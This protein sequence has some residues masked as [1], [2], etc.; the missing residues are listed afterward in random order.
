[1]ADL[2]LLKL[3]FLGGL[4]IHL[5]NEPVRLGGSRKAYG[6]LAYLTMAGQ[7]GQQRAAIPRETLATLFWP[8]ND[9][10]RALANL[11][12]QL[13]SLRQHLAP[14]LDIQ[15]HS[16]A[17]VWQPTVE[18]D[19][20]N[21]EKNLK[22]AS[23]GNS[24]TPLTR[25]RAAR[26]SAAVALYAGDFLA[27]FYLRN[28]P[29]FDDWTLFHQERLRLKL[30]DGLL[31]LLAFYEERHQIEAGIEHSLRLLQ[32]DPLNETGHR[33]LMRFQA[34]AGQHDLAL[35][36]FDELVTLLAVE[37]AVPPAAET[38]A[39]YEQI[40]DDPASFTPPIPAG[41]Q[42]LLPIPAPP[43]R[44]VGR[45]DELTQIS[46]ALANPDCRLL[47]ITG[48]GG[49]GKSRLAATVARQQ[50]GQFQHGV[51][52]LPLANLHEETELALSLANSLQIPLEHRATIADQL[53]SWLA[54]RELLLVLDNFE[55]LRS[56][57]NLAL[58]QQCLQTA[59]ELKLLITSR[60]RLN[61]QS[62][63]TLALP[64]LALA[65]ETELSPA[66][67]L[68]LER[69]AQAGVGL[70]QQP[71]AW[72]AVARI[73][74]LAAGQPLA[75][76]LAASWV[77]LLSPTE[78][79]AE[80]EH[81]ISFL[82][83]DAADL[84]L[85]HRSLRAV[86]DSSWLMLPPAEQHLYASLAIFRG[87]FS[88]AAAREITGATLLQL[89]ALVDKSLLGRDET[90]RFGHH[91]MLQE[92]A[93]EQLSRQPELLARCRQN[94]LVYYANWAT[95][96]RPA[97]VG[98]SL[99]ETM[100]Q[101]ARE[102]DN[103]RQAWQIAGQ[104]AQWPAIKQLFS[105]LGNFFKYSSQFYTARQWLQPMRQKLAAAPAGTDQD[106]LLLLTVRAAQFNSYLNDDVAASQ[107]LQDAERLALQSGDQSQ[108]LPIYQLM[109]ILAESQGQYDEAYDAIQKGLDSA[110]RQDQPG[111]LFM[112]LDSAAIICCQ[113]GQ[114]EEAMQYAREAAILSETIGSPAHAAQSNL[115]FG[116]IAY[117]KQQY[118]VAEPLLQQSAAAYGALNLA[119]GQAHALVFLGACYN[120]RQAYAA[121]R[122]T[123]L[124]AIQLHEASHQPAL[125]AFDRA[126]L[127]HTNLGCGQLEEAAR[128]LRE[129][130][131]LLPAEPPT[132][133]HCHILA[134]W[135][136]WFLA[137]EQPGRARQLAEI[138]ATQPAAGAYLQ[139]EANLMLTSLAHPSS[140]QP[141]TATDQV[142]LAVIWQ[143]LQTSYAAPQ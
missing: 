94:Y 49:N 16:V 61:L 121:A 37:L 36:H 4:H 81:G 133:T 9:T 119:S 92:F 122:E 86:F 91:P 5:A 45:A 40:R 7:F 142:D 72:P 29:E 138:V 6:L 113:L 104:T 140:I 120:G 14:F 130:M 58:L 11:S 136:A 78:I 62:E 26:L 66:M 115:I 89:A 95:A 74:A 103:L 8:Q 101:V 68:F 25:S 53:A 93:T 139:T 59:P 28:C 141:A 47:T 34:Q 128:Q 127:A 24:Q 129:A 13:T 67:N 135:A 134:G 22:L 83:T 73:C 35:S 110:R 48:L 38:T 90:G 107:L 109:A 51:Y 108:N 132:R 114:Y 54:P 19:V 80:M 111:S 12:V 116:T 143:E 106:V 50:L 99:P 82:A 20:V 98:P 75:L 79:V 27:G 84:P 105:L 112:M 46:H 65:G 87:G 52:W 64:G 42:T 100:A 131:A 85:R 60:E 39:L 76:E 41:P 125:I 77:R 69:A 33:Y 43:N 71:G 97:L 56:P 10:R 102:I 17:F 126:H 23:S 118:T 124:Q 1:M 15:R 137:H 63:W 30:L 88:L 32:F 70:R 96:L 44:F 2:P 31:T 21:L 57:A 18:L 123:L 117:Y 55:Q 3:Q